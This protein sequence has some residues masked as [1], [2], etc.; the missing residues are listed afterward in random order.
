M[1]EEK[2]Q[3]LTEDDLKAID[4]DIDTAKASLDQDTLKKVRE[5]AKAEVE[6]EMVA[7][8]ELE[9]KDSKIA[10]LQKR[11]EESTKNSAEA[12][13]KLKSK[14]DEMVTSKQVMQPKD[15]FTPAQGQTTN[16][17]GN[18]NMNADNLTDKEVDR[19]EVESGK[20][21]FG[22]EKYDSMRRDLG[23]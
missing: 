13:D 12:L 1:A 2:E 7:K 6:K 17:Q 20:A 16:A 23:L 8:K 5:E 15:P 4:K 22:E 3:K 19:I 21:F 18:P 9:D 11:L 14:V 10:D